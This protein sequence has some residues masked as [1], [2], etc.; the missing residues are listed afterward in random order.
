[1]VISFMA[2]VLGVPVEAL[3]VVVA[4]HELAHAYTHLG[5]DIDGK[6]WDTNTFSQVDPR[7][8][9]GLA[10]FYTEVICKKLEPR[11][12]VPGYL[13][14]GCCTFGPPTAA[15]FNRRLHMYTLQKLLTHKSPQMTQ[16][17]AHLRDETLKKAAG[18]AGDLIGQAIAK[19]Q[20]KVIV[21]LQNDKK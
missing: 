17:Y 20:D 5:R 3:T 16:R 15:L 4:V 11:F 6:K 18:L 9:E 14:T 19:N 10:Q 2:G 12:Y 8:S 7:T 1:M 13:L 21:N